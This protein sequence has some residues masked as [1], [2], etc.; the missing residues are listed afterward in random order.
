[1]ETREFTCEDCG[2]PF[3]GPVRMGM[4]L[5][6]QGICRLCQ[7]RN[8]DIATLRLVGL[9]VV[10]ALVMVVILVVAIKCG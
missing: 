8:R 6:R 3:I 4:P 2:E 9:G 5:T 7:K 1:M 10:F